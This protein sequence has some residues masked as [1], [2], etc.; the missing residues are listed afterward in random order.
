ME[1]ISEGLMQRLLP[2]FTLEKFTD[3]YLFFKGELV[4]RVFVLVEGRLDYY[5][6]DGS[7]AKFRQEPVVMNA[8]VILYK[9]VY[10]CESSAFAL[11]TCYV[12]S[13]TLGDFQKALDESIRS[14]GLSQILS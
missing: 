11:D 7:L 6:K 5:A 2:Y 10:T 1:A 12:I 4:D 3:C 8:E 9:D 14:L 13:L